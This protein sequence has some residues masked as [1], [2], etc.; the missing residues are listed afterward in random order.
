MLKFDKVDGEARVVSLRPSLKFT[1]A[2]SLVAAQTDV[3][4]VD[5]GYIFFSSR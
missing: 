5:G 2:G 1:M 4:I 3:A